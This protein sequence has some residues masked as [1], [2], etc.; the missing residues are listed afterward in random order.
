QAAAIHWPDCYCI[1]ATRGQIPLVVC[2][3][4]RFSIRVLLYFNGPQ[5]ALYQNGTMDELKREFSDKAMEDF[6]LIDRAVAHDDEQ[7]FARL[8]QRYRRP[9]YHM[10]LKMVR[11]VDDAEDLT[12]ESFRSEERRVG[13]EEE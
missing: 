2:Y 3:R 13:E 6:R 7:A 11:N 4:L 12:I 10:I 5:G 1:A 8:L 9:V